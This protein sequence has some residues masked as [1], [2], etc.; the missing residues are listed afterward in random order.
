[1]S[2][3][4]KLFV[5]PHVCRGLIHSHIL[6]SNLSFEIVFSFRLGAIIVASGTQTFL[7]EQM[8]F[9]NHA[10]SIDAAASEVFGHHL[11]A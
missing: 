11:F 6:I 8:R 5:A 7:L 3:G 9:L 4:Y 10:A 1:M 2:F